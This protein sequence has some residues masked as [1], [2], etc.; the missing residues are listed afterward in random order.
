MFQVSCT[1]HQEYKILT[2]Q[3]PVQVVM[4]TGGSS[5]RHIRDEMMMGA[6]RPKHAEK[7]CSNKICI[8][9]NHVHV[10]FNL[11]VVSVK[12]LIYSVRSAF[13]KKFGEHLI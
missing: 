12:E 5:L 6:L 4:V 8:L 3:P 2:W 13:K 11:M 7:V 9:L 1:H 10:L